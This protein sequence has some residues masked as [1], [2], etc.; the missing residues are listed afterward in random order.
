MKDKVE[1]L[2][3]LVTEHKPGNKLLDFVVLSSRG[4]QQATKVSSSIGHLFSIGVPS[5]A[6]LIA[7]LSAFKT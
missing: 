4:P 2:T 7:S 1:V 5:K 3:Y 6:A